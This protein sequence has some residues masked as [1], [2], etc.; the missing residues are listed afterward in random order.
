MRPLLGGEDVCVALWDGRS[1]SSGAASVGLFIY[2]PCAFRI[3][4]QYNWMFCLLFLYFV[5]Y[6][7]KNVNKTKKSQKCKQA[8]LDCSRQNSDACH[9][10]PQRH[11]TQLWMYFPF[12]QVFICFTL[13]CWLCRWEPPPWCTLLPC[14]P[15]RCPP[16]ECRWRNSTW[17]P[18]LQQT[19]S[20]KA[21][22]QSDPSILHRPVL[23][24]CAA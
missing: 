12:C 9:L 5:V 11:K 3:T 21:A 17:K 8:S 15:P 6:N 10:P 14:S 2:L 22:L 24:G 13:S 16:E 19:G 18:L 23:S 20:G 4:D 7:H 1:A